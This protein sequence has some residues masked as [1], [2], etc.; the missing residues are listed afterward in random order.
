M[1]WIELHQQRQRHPKTLRLAALL[2]KDRRYA[3][4]LLDDLWTW[5]LDAADEDGALYGLEES[6]IAVALDYPPAKG[7]TLVSALIESGYLDE[8]DGTY[9]LHDWAD[10]SGGF[11]TQRNA[12]RNANRERQRRY[13]ERNN[14]QNE[15][16]CNASVTRD[17]AVTVT[18]NDDGRNASVTRDTGV[19]VTQNN[20]ATNT[21]TNTYTKT[22]TQG[23]NI[24]INN[25]RHHHRHNP[26]IIPP[27][28][29]DDDDGVDPLRVY[30]ANNLLPMSPG[31]HASLA[32]LMDAGMTDELVRYAVDL[33]NAQGV[34]T[35]AY[36]QSILNRWICEGVRTLAEAKAKKTAYAAAQKQATRGY[37]ERTYTQT[38]YDAMF[39]NLS[40]GEDAA[41]V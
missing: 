25:H 40:E 13:R 20:G 41:G 11:V 36:V 35:W 8:R 32:E 37:Q 17:K 1:A 9:Y 28:G 23:D 10:Y 22:N 24:N 12:R 26:P 4:G 14:L 5:G 15:C 38:E 34:R 6:D 16:D 21:Y 2:K 30:L 39:E 31:N 27:G 7:K 29:D 3:C 33:A 18:Q 19:T